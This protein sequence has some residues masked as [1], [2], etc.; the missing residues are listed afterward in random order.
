MLASYRPGGNVVKARARVTAL[1]RSDVSGRLTFVLK[2][3]GATL[4]HVT[5]R[6][7]GE[8]VAVKKFRRIMR[9]GRYVVVAK[10][11]GTG[12]FQRSS[13]RVRLT[14]A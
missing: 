8:G 12:T 4:H 5:V 7:A 9:P 11:L 10:Y 13:D 3:N 14:L 2:R 1:G 6:L